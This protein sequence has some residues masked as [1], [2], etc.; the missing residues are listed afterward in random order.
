MG[1]DAPEPTK[2]LLVEDETMVR[3]LIA[4]LLTA[5]GYRV[6]TA[7]NASEARMV[8]AEF[9]PD[10]LVADIQL[11][12]G[13]TGI[14]L[15]HALSQDQGLRGMVFLTNVPEPRLIGFDSKSIPKGSA[16]L[17]KS[18]LADTRVLV[19]AI[20]ASRSGKVPLIYR[21]DHSIDP[22]I[23]ELSRSQIDVLRL[24]AQGHSNLQIAE[25]R[26]T[27][28]RAVE[29]LLHRAYE[30]LGIDVETSN[31]NMRVNAVLAYLE[32]IGAKRG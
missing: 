27:G 32:T 30:V 23:P 31:A 11:G 19:D 25:I 29:N 13:P 16:Y 22:D 4:E 9:V 28:Q 5:N 14:D 8:A 3:S 7:G 20:E 18:R 1:N 21:D 26:G 2:V 10:V 15:A 6:I 12:G 17:N 24:V